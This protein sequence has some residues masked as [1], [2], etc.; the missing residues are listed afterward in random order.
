[1]VDIHIE[2]AKNNLEKKGFLDIYI[3]VNLD[4]FAEI[5]RLKKEK[6]A[7][8]LAHYYQEPDIQDVADFIGDSLGLA[9]KAQST[10]ADIIVFAGVH[11]MAETA[12]ILNPGKKVL[13]PDLKAGCSLADSAPPELFKKFKDE[14]PG[15]IV[16][17][18]INC[19]AGIKALS[20]I[21][22]TSSNAQAIIE[23][24]PKDQK[25]IFA[26]DKN[27][28][29]YLKKKTGRD[30]VLW[31]GSCIVHE[32]FSLEKITK[33]KIRH[34]K[35]KVIAHPECEEP[36]LRI[37]DFIGSTTALL[38]YTIE[39]DAQEFIVVTE[40]GILHQMQIKSPA[41]TFIPAPP[42]NMCACNDCPYMK[43]N[44]LEKLYLCMEYEEPQIRMDEE[45]VNCF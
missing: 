30:M 45:F 14:Y 28:G 35:A 37:A 13:L 26:P 8:V 18:Y 29:A 44:T 22:C 40:T 38:K 11:F 42:D 31:N 1:M 20:D 17:S 25:I 24:L 3:D 34:P 6:N 19:S 15:H 27:L 43:L 39:N 12:K 7:I 32:I 4:L 16:I 21:I 5:E 36:V 10:D 9:Q 2:T 41:K 33:L 23:S